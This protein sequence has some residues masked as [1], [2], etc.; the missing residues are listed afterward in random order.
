Q[1]VMHVPLKTERQV[2]QVLQACDEYELADCRRDICKIWAR[3]N[4]GHNRLGPAIAYFA[5]ADQPRRINAVAE[6]LL[7]EYL[8][9]G[10]CELASIELI[11]SINKEVQQQCG[12]L[13]F[14]SHYRSFHE[15]Y[16]CKEF[17]RAAKTLTSLFSSD[18]A[19]RS[20]WPMLLVDALPLLEGEDVVFDAEDTYELMR[21]LE[22]L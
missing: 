5:H 8:R 16:K 12:R 21:C 19:P 18:V 13:S 2:Q 15:Q 11:D 3:K 7:D 4:Y 10:M 20:F 14:L 9:R 1:L 6:Q 22:E 17:A